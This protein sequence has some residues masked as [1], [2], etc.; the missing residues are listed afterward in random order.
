MKMRKPMAA[1]DEDLLRKVEMVKAKAVCSRR[2]GARRGKGRTSHDEERRRMSGIGGRGDAQQCRKL[3]VVSDKSRNHRLWH[4]VEGVPGA[5]HGH[6]EGEEEDE[7]HE[8]AVLDE[9]VE[10]E[11]EPER[12]QEEHRDGRHQE[13]PQGPCQ[14]VHAVH[15]AHRRHRLPNHKS[16][17]ARH[18]PRLEQSLNVPLE[19]ASAACHWIAPALDRPYMGSSLRT[20]GEA[21]DP[22]RTWRRR[23]SFSVT[24]LLICTT[25]LKRAAANRN[26]GI[27]W[28]G[29]WIRAGWAN[30]AYEGSH[31]M[32]Q[33]EHHNESQKKDRKQDKGKSTRL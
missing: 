16:Q 11:H 7:E 17:V 27:S 9:D 30:S 10:A 3:E 12:D 25:R 24:M 6:P 21:Q 19:C 8:E 2:R 22:G 31:S 5:Y 18:T 4:E 23:S 15:Q 14:P 1:V 32:S 33:S 26:T 29:S 20:V 28:L 13:L